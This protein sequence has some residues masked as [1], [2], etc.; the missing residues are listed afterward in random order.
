MS[1]TALNP[2]KPTMAHAIE[3]YFNVALYLLVLTGFG[4]LAST[5]GLDLPAVL[6]VGL[7]LLLRGCQLAAHLEFAIPDSWT[8]Y[9]TLLYIFVYFAD[10]FFV[11][12]SFLAATVHL[13]LFLMVVRL[14][15]LQ[16]PRDH[17][18]L[19]VL[20]FL[21]VLGA[22]VLTVDS[23]FLFSFA[24]FLLVAVITFVLMEMRHSLAEEH[25][26]GQEPRITSPYGRMA[27]V[28]L[29]TAPL[30]VLLIMAGSFLIFFLL[31]RVSSRYLSAYTSTND[32][33]TGFTDRVELGRIGQIQ[34]SS[35]VVMH[36][37][38]QNDMQGAYD[39]KWRGVALNRF[40]GKMWS[41]AF[42][43]KLVRPGPDGSYRLPP[44]MN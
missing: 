22:A 7:A 4:T 3:R 13:V 8:N 43:A 18:M 29:A 32:L 30:L 14:F 19:A 6:L 20:S 5:G 34:Q 36:I 27:Y 41:N 37:E 10:Y 24:G 42:G 40:D 16:R 44:A 38:I 35:A 39:L 15:S 31:P 2:G 17:Y 12:R 23:V 9:L 11:S 25:A 26:R 21:M 28:L 1:S 33:S